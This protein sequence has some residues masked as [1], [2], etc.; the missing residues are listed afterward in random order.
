MDNTRFDSLTRALAETRSRRGLKPLVVGLVL[1]SSLG[2]LEA[3]DSEAK[4]KRR[5]KKKKKKQI[6]QPVPPP[7]PPPCVP[8]PQATVCAG[9]PCET[10]RYNTCGQAVTCTC[11]TGQSCLSNGSCA[12]LCTSGSCPTA[13]DGCSAPHSQLQ[14]ICT[15]D[16]SCMGRQTCTSTID[17]PR[18]SACVPCGM[19]GLRCFPICTG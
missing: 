6:T 14:Q 4:K 7:P 9:A 2:L 10:V 8:E 13:C 19:A 18:G 3:S 1:G 17:C 15:F 11:P 16:V 12:I 5:K